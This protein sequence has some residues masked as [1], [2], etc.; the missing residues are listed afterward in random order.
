MCTRYFGLLAIVP[1]LIDGTQSN[2]SFR[3]YLIRSLADLYLEA[4][5]TSHIG[6]NAKSGEV[7]STDG[8]RRGAK[9]KKSM[10]TGKVK[11]SNNDDL[12]QIRNLD[13][14]LYNA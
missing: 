1:G 6:K 8:H 2:L 9:L 4:S 11:K 3:S 5:K 14:G 10:E 12:P 7:K 13:Y